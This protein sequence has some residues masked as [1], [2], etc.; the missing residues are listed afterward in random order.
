MKDLE[1]IAKDLTAIEQQ[2]AEIAR[3]VQRIALPSLFID[4]GDEAAPANDTQPEAPATPPRYHAKFGRKRWTLDEERLLCELY[5]MGG[6][7][8]AIADQLVDR[9]YPRRTPEALARKVSELRLLT[10]KK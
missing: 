6:A 3:Q 7:W 10:V 8:Q 2:L 5:R 4:N 9:G 1:Q